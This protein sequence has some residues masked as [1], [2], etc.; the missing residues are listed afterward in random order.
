MLVF[1]HAKL[2]LGLQV[3]RRRPDGF[4]DLST[5]MVPI[6][7]LYD[8]LEFVPASADSFTLTGLEVPGSAEDNICRKAL[9]LMRE[10]VQVPPLEV[11]LHKAIPMGAGLGGGSAD[12]AFMLRALAQVYA[13]NTS[14]LKLHEMA[15]KLGSDCPFFVL[16]R[17]AYATGRGD[18]LEPLDLPLQGLGL[19]VL[20][21][22]IHIATAEAYANIAP[23]DGRGDLRNLL[24]AEPPNEWKGKLENDFEAHAFKKYPKLKAL[25]DSL[26]DSGA[27]Y[28]A[29]TGSGSAVYGLYGKNVDA[30]NHPAWEGCFVHRSTL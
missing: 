1:P 16:N 11:H 9:K 18:L 5:V 24:T 2:N 20:Y 27:V 17:T 26:Y 28:A 14:D 23:R 4:H 19:V 12:G 30:L 13:P 10:V 6:P 25:V 3:L 7:G 8:A 21:A 22:G 29:M 15:G